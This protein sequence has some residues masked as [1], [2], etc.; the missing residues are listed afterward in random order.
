MNIYVCLRPNHVLKSILWSYFNGNNQD[1]FIIGIGEVSAM[2]R[3]AERMESFGYLVIKADL[4]DINKK[5]FDDKSLFKKLMNVFFSRKIINE[6]MKD[7][8]IDYRKKKGL[9]LFHDQ[10]FLSNYFLYKAFR[11]DI[12]VFLLEDGTAN[13]LFKR[14]FKNHY[15]F[16]AGIFPLGYNPIISS[17]YLMKP[18]EYKGLF[19]NKI[20]KLDSKYVK[21]TNDD[22]VNNKI[23]K[24]FGVEFFGNNN[25]KKPFV[26]ITQPL[27]KVGILNYQE[28]L[29]VYTKISKS[30]DGFIVVKKHPQDEFDYSNICDM[31]IG[32]DIPFEIIID[33]FPEGTEF[34]TL[35]SSVA[36]VSEKFTIKSL[37]NFRSDN[38]RE[39]ILKLLNIDNI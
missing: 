31:Q 14:P 12:E 20:K 22:S 18:K 37:I 28:K 36:N 26:I 4:V 19:R 8:V 23:K 3:I 27:D 30:L 25:N 1:I 33:D 7:K 2:L 39:D 11:K 6:V 9:Y 21:L 34:F 5:I 13:Y 16:L 17:I 38:K 15:K 29:D 10:N 35:Y 24:I 32:G